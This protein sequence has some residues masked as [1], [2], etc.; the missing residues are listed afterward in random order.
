V[1]QQRLRYTP[2]SSGHAGVLQAKPE[3]RSE[4]T[5]GSIGARSKPGDDEPILR[6]QTDIPLGANT[7]PQK[8]RVR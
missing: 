1:R 7:T 2:V 4:L 8:S 5:T 3:D 6:P